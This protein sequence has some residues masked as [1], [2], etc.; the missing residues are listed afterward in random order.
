MKIVVLG[1]GALGSI[2][3]GHL[4]KSGENVTLLARGERA[5]YLKKNGITITGLAR[6]NTPCAITT[7]PRQL[8]EAD[9]LIVTV[10]TYDMEAALSSVAHAKFSYVTSVQNGVMANEQLASVFGSANTIGASAGFSGEVLPGGEV[11]FTANGGFDVGELPKG[12]SQRTRELSDALQKSGVNS[13]AIDD[14]LSLQWSKFAMWVG[15]TAIGVLTR[16]ETYKFASDPDCALTCVRIVREAASI[17]AKMD[18]PIRDS[19]PIPVQAMVDAGVDV[20]TQHQDCTKTIVEAAE[21]AGIFVSGYH[22]DASPAAPNAWLTGAAWNWG[23]VYSEI[24]AEIRKGTYKSSVMFQGL[25]A[26][27][28]Q[29]SPFGDFL[30]DDVKQRALDTVEKLRTGSFQPFTG[31]I[32]DQDGVV[33][34]AAGVVPTDADLQST[35]YL[36]QGITGRTN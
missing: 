30:P 11:R 32:T 36:L 16:L 35:G 18:I 9:A 4:A 19:G 34:I 22:Q 10:K 31:P 13:K 17:A 14:V 15:F 12:S 23:P 25:D 2:I 29:L 20:L 21:R 8:Y 24:V 6:F 26:G 28:V 27:W 3:A 1:A 7:D 5:V 33:Q